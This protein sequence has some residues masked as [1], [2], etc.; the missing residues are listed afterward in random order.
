MP[1]IVKTE[2]GSVQADA[3]VLA[4]NAYGRLEPKKLSNLVFP[5]GSYIIATEPLPEDT[6]RENSYSTRTSRSCG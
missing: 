4:G 2:Q 3:V 5:A 6:A 1:L